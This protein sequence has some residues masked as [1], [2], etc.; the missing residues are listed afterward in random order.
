MTY[1]IEEVNKALQLLQTKQRVLQDPLL[2]AQVYFD[3]KPNE[4]QTQFLIELQVENLL[5]HL[6]QSCRGGGKTII[7]AIAIVWAALKYPRFKALILSG[8]LKK[9]YVCASE[10]C[11]QDD[12]KR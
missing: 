8:I 12:K 5:G 11:V 2:L 6:L 4:G 10:N 9:S 3:I 1:T 7:A